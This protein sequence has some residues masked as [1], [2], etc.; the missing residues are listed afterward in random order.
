MTDLRREA[1]RVPEA[2]RRLDAV[3]VLRRGERTTHDG[4]FERTAPPC[5]TRVLDITAWVG[6]S[7]RGLSGRQ[8]FSSRDRVHHEQINTTFALASVTVAVREA[9]DACGATNAE[10]EATSARA[11]TIFIICERA[12]R[13]GTLVI[14]QQRRCG[15][16]HD[17]LLRSARNAVIATN[18]QGQNNQRVRPHLFFC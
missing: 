11:S 12:A 8:L 9:V 15:A 7:W 6:Q 16:A 10:A 1:E 17:A 4:V 3:H 14:E 5:T 13:V 18:L 2:E